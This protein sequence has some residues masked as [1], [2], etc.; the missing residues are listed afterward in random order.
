[1]TLVTEQQAA[2]DLYQR[3]FDQP[4]L[5]GER[6]QI[7]DTVR[8][9]SNVNQAELAWQA[10]DDR[11]VYINRQEV[12]ITEHGDWA[13][14]QLY[15]VYENVTF[16]RQEVVYY[17]SLPESAVITG[18]WLGNSADRSKAFEFQVVPRGAA[19]ALYRN[20]I[21]Y[22]RDPALVEQIG[23]RQYRLRAF[24]VEPMEWVAGSDDRKPG[25]ELHQTKKGFASPMCGLP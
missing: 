18:L 3:F 2:A 21:R 12:S 10:V 4:I 22:N 17:F 16:Q 1:V 11:E 20:E 9:T 5:V 15:E 24:P 13:D 19:Q 8:S 14:V 23:P 7:V 6:K 25:P